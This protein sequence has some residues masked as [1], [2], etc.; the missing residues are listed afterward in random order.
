LGNYQQ[1]FPPG[2]KNFINSEQNF[3]R[4]GIDGAEP[5]FSLFGTKKFFGEV[6]SGTFLKD[7][8]GVILGPFTVLITGGDLE[9]TGQA[10]VAGVD[11]YGWIVSQNRLYM[12]NETVID[13]HL[14]LPGHSAANDFELNFILDATQPVAT[15]EPIGNDNNYLRVYL[16]SDNAAYNIGITK[17]INGAA[18]VVILAPAVVVAAEGTFRIKIEDDGEYTFYYHDGAGDVDEATDEVVAKS[19]IGLLFDKGYVVYEM[20]TSDAVLRTLTS[21]QV[22][23]TYPN[24]D[25]KYDLEDA[26]VNK[27][28]CEIWDGDPDG[29]GVQ[30]F[31]E[32]H[33]FAGDC[34]IQN[35]LVRFHIAEGIIRGLVL[36]GYISGAWLNTRAYIQGYAVE[37]PYLQKIEF[38]SV[39]KIAVIIHLHDIAD[40]DDPNWGTYRI[41]LERGSYFFRVEVIERVPMPAHPTLYM[42][43]VAPYLHFNYGGDAELEKIADADLTINAD[44]QNTQSDNFTVALDEGV[45]YMLFFAFLKKPT[46]TWSYWTNR[47]Y[48]TYFYAGFADMKEGE[49]EFYYGVIPFSLSANLFREAEY[50]FDQGW[51]GATPP[52]KF[53]P[54]VGESATVVRFDAQNE[55]IFYQFVGVTDLPVGRY[56][57]L[58]RSYGVGAVQNYRVRAWCTAAGGYF[59][60]QE[61][62]WVTKQAQ[63]AAWTYHGI[64]FDITTEEDGDTIQIEAEQNNAGP[65]TVYIDYILL[66]PISNGESWPQDLSHS[67]LRGRDQNKKVYVR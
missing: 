25:S 26:D 52:D 19:D 51:Y 24:F 39:N 10:A 42:S 18:P 5:L 41:T 64:I 27:G 2:S 9:I 1:G 3:T 43:Q 49:N 47:Y 63:N 7:N 12:L 15:Q 40:D 37:H 23:V 46:G 21:E 16:W 54:G 33:E 30:V 28:V 8:D 62:A 31:D 67:A 38:Y 34:Y 45:A 56:F 65:N 55:N 13:I 11:A 20:V 17:R 22:V 58:I 48:D 57:A 59:L 44:A 6:L 14:K 50:C 66:I 53:D 32:D 61:K 36:W 35:G 4:T 60:N 29:V